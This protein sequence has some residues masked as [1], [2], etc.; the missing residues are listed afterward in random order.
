MSAEVNIR[1]VALGEL[2]QE[3]DDAVF[4]Q[5]LGLR[6][7]QNFDRDAEGLRIV[8]Q[9]FEHGGGGSV[10]DTGGDGFVYVP[11]LLQGFKITNKE[12]NP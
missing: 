10:P 2:M 11:D 6:I 7:L 1:S 12:A 5:E 9:V 8:F 3:K 4:I